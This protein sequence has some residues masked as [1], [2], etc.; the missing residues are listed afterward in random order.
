MRKMVSFRLLTR[1]G[2]IEK[3]ES[4]WGIEKQII[5]FRVLTLY[6]LVTE[7][8]LQGQWQH[9]AEHSSEITLH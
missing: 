3:S 1:V 9:Y 6:Y 7:T 8:E 2:K 5:G 4:S